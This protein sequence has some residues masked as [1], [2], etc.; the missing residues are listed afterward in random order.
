MPLEL[1]DLGFAP[2]YEI[3]IN[4]EYPVAGD[5][6]IPAFRLGSPRHGSFRAGE[7]TLTVRIRQ[8]GASPW[9]ASFA[10]VASGG[11]IRGLFA[12]PNPNQLLVATGTNAYLIDVTQ[13]GNVDDL[14]VG[15][16]VDLQRPSGTDLLVIGSFTKLAAVDDVGLRWVTGRLFL[17][18]LDLVTGPP[19]KIYVRGS[20]HPMPGDPELLVIDP[21]RGEIIEGHRYTD[22]AHPRGE[23]GWRRP[24]L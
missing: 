6:G 8:R 11:L 21:S 2:S 1:T 20:P 3:D 23:S 16:V 19:G 15:P 13:P 24:G 12:C 22:F 18:D 5:W 9:V 14:P 4:P 7:E 10:V 17:D